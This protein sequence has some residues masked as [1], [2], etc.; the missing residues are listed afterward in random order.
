MTGRRAMHIDFLIE[1]ASGK[2][3]LDGMLGS[4]LPPSSG[5]TWKVHSYR[6]VGHIPAKGTCDPET[7]RSR[8]L[9]DNVPRIL[10]GI[11]A[12]S[13]SSGFAWAVVV[14]CDL[15][16]KNQATFAA[17]LQGLLSGIPDAPPTRFCLAI[18]EGEAW[19][20]GDVPAILKAYPKAN[21]AILKGYSND[22]IC[23][24]WELLAEA[25]Y[26]GGAHALKVNGYHAVGTEKCNWAKSIT[27]H[28]DLPNNKS[29][30]FKSFVSAVMQLSRKDFV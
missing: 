6:G 1:D 29:P 16:K 3:M 22:S 9:L 8:A 30:S 5:V 18:E 7:I 19:L 21:R 27:L 10:A 20:L 11:G 23:G 15:D 14:V 13:K 17:Q 2:I 12:A 25:V 28:M 24:S 26:P 4:L